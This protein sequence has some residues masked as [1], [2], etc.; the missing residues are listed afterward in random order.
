ME[1]REQFQYWLAL[2]GSLGYFTLILDG[3]ERSSDFR[4]LEVD[5]RHSRHSRGHGHGH[6]HNHGST[7]AENYED[8]DKQQPP[9][10]YHH[11]ASLPTDPFLSWL[12]TYFPPRVTVIISAT[13]RT[14][15]GVSLHNSLGHDHKTQ[16]GHGHGHHHHSTSNSGHPSHHHHHHS[17][18]HRQS[19]PPRTPRCAVEVCVRRLGSFFGM[20]FTHEHIS[21]S[22]S[23]G[24]SSS[25]GNSTSSTSNA[26]GTNVPH[27]KAQEQL[28]VLGHPSCRLAVMPLLSAECKATILSLFNRQ[29]NGAVRQRLKRVSVG[30]CETVWF[31]LFFHTHP[32]PLRAYSHP[33]AGCLVVVLPRLLLVVRLATRCSFTSFSTLSLGHHHSSSTHNHEC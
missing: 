20:P 33:Q 32:L 12:P 7:S 4:N 28:K 9:Q 24:N 5:H 19:S 26:A 1:L 29:H 17:N 11:P 16:N 14:G 3:V 2:A 15:G 22:S 18:H 27:A 31:V 8:N 25:D 23:S 13:P 30:Y 6:N 10:F 21:R